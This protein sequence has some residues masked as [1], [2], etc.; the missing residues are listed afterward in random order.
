MFGFEL[1]LGFIVMLS[2]LVDFELVF[3]DFV[4]FFGFF[5]VGV[6]NELIGVYVVD[7]YVCFNGFGVLVIIF[8]FGEL[9]VLC[10][11]GG[12]YCEFVFVFYIVGYFIILV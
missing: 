8:G 6:L 3:F 2:C 11:I 1:L 4:E 5:W 7:G 9:S 10:G 12:L